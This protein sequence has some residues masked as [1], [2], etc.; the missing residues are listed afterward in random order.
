MAESEAKRAYKAAWYLEN[1][2]RIAARMAA[3]YQETREQRLAKA[4]I[5]KARYAAL[6][7][8]KKQL[9]VK[10]A[11]LRDKLNPE[12]AKARTSL[13]RKRHQQATP[14][15]LTKEHKRAIKAL[16]LKAMHLTESTGVEHHVDH[17]VPLSNPTVCGLHVPW[18]L[19]VLTAAENIQ[20]ANRIL[21]NH[22]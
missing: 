20:K 7:P 5:E 14:S 16:Y 1:K 21:F 19:Q 3:R 11:S 2:A 6:P 10:A 9:K 4:K 12:Q 17:I 18:N 8:E 22:A 13:R 15:W